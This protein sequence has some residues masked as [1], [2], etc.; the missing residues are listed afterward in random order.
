MVRSIFV[1]IEAQ[2]VSFCLSTVV[3]QYL[4]FVITVVTFIYGLHLIWLK[5]KC[6]SSKVCS[7]SS[8][9]SLSRLLFMRYINSSPRR[10]KLKILSITIN[11]LWSLCDKN[12]N[13]QTDNNV[14]WKSKFT[15]SVRKL[16]AF[17]LGIYCAIVLVPRVNTWIIYQLKRLMEYLHSARIQKE[18]CTG[19]QLGQ[20]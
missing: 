4:S 1:H 3:Y 17:I 14:C 18:K 12:I 10:N 9:S 20:E 2:I 15:D 8:S 13:Y 5:F 16:Y 19:L 11:R 6:V 7:I